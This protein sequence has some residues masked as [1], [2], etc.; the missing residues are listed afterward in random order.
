MDFQGKSP[1]RRILVIVQLQIV[2]LSVLLS[3]ITTLICKVNVTF[4]VGYMNQN[5]PLPHVSSAAQII[6]L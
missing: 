4:L 1:S 2:H 5:L 6:Y 3:Q